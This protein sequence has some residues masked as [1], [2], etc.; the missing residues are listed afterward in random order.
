MEV[1]EAIAKALKA[2]GTETLFAYPV[3]PTIEAATVSPRNLTPEG[4]S[5]L[6]INDWAR[7]TSGTCAKHNQEDE[8]GR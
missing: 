5:W 8:F 3:S 2:E 7:V 1:A 6:R 4:R